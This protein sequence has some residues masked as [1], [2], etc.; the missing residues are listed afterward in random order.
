ME[1]LQQRSWYQVKHLFDELETPAPELFTEALEKSLQTLVV[2]RNSEL[3]ISILLFMQE[4][5]NELFSTR[6]HLRHFMKCC[7]HLL[8]NPSGSDVVVQAVVLSTMTCVLISCDCIRAFPRMFEGF[9]GVLLKYTGDTEA[10][11]SYIRKTACECLRELEQCYPHLLMDSSVHMSILAPLVIHFQRRNAKHPPEKDLVEHVF[12]QRESAELALHCALWGQVGLADLCIAELSCAFS[13]YVSLLLLFVRHAVVLAMDIL[14]EGYFIYSV[15]ASD[16]PTTTFHIPKG[17]VIVSEGRIW[18]EYP[19][20]QKVARAAFDS[21][22][23]F[24]WSGTGVDSNNLMNRLRHSVGPSS[25]ASSSRKTLDIADVASMVVRRFVGLVLGHVTTLHMFNRV[26]LHRI[27]LILGP[28]FGSTQENGLT[29]HLHRLTSSGKPIFRHM[30]LIHEM[31]DNGNGPLCGAVSSAGNATYVRFNLVVQHLYQHYTSTPSMQAVCVS[32]LLG[33]VRQD[34]ISDDLLCYFSSVRRTWADRRPSVFSCVAACACAMFDVMLS[35]KREAKKCAVLNE[36]DD[37]MELAA[38]TDCF[39]DAALFSPSSTVQR[40]VCRLL[41][42]VAN[43]ETGKSAMSFAIRLLLKHSITSEFCHGLGVNGHVHRC[44]LIEM[45]V[46]FTSACIASLYKQK[47]LKEVEH[48]VAQQ[49]DPIVQYVASSATISLMPLLLPLI[50]YLFTQPRIDIKLLISTLVQ[51][52]HRCCD[53]SQE[54]YSF[55]ALSNDVG[56]EFHAATGIDETDTT[57][58]ATGNAILHCCRTLA[59]HR[60]RK[61]PTHA[62]TTAC[63]CKWLKRKFLQLCLCVFL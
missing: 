33:L 43:E 32:W 25:N 12:C 35:I 15:T 1:D 51:F 21:S 16:Q 45:F 11:D 7:D 46:Q 5:G 40:I 37:I 59:Q 34:K 28:L 4:Y 54:R 19:Q 52:V 49:L 9:V 31:V 29:F 36:A 55:V 22:N 58:W 39:S 17:T 61:S 48:F 53:Q 63:V 60:S 2:T 42:Q 18:S 24:L 57:T 41:L 13:S 38:W 27:L 47:T 10:T 50:C 6:R 44:R 14:D 8:R 62:C 26:E 3:Q 20:S 56:G 23:L 30:S